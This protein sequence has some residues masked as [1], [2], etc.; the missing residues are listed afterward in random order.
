MVT[1]NIKS[2]SKNTQSHKKIQQ[3]EQRVVL[4]NHQTIDKYYPLMVFFYQ[5]ITKV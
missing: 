3:F 2:F 4:C 5:D 1:V